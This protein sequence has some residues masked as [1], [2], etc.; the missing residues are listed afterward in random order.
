MSYN[1]YIER[2]QLEQIQEFSKLDLNELDPND[3][4]L[5]GKLILLAYNP[6]TRL[7]D[8]VYYDPGSGGSGGGLTINQSTLTVDH[9]VNTDKLPVPR[10]F[11][12]KA[13]W[14]IDEVVEALC[15]PPIP[16]VLS[17]TA[18]PKLIEI[19]ENDPTKNE[20]VL[21]YN[22]DAGSEG[23]E[24]L[25]TIEY[26]RGNTHITSNID[27]L[28]SSTYGYVTYK[29]RFLTTGSGDYPPVLKEA[30]DRVKVVY[31]FF[32]GAGPS[33]TL[34]SIGQLDDARKQILH[35]IE[36]T[37]SMVC[38]FNLIIP[39]ATPTPQNYYWFAVQQS[40]TPKEW[41]AID[42]A[43]IED[44]F[45]RGPIETAFENIG[46]L[47]YRGVSYKIYMGTQVTFYFKRIK[48]KF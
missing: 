34:A 27:H 37:R 35:D 30:T 15:N 23:D 14:T 45:N 19:N 40:F 9:I 13:G 6:P 29:V 7:F 26:F 32:I 1:P 21:N 20:V 24:D 43:G 16:G 2:I 22:F 36:L 4:D 39:P 17:L 48:I 31:P 11:A 3:L 44:P 18:L 12:F 47:S 10:G 38:N 25:N 42:D 33:N 5:S 46:N 8:V 41:V 28:V